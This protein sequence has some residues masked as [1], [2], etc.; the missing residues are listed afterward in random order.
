MA[1]EEKKVV[2]VGQ[3]PQEEEEALV[4]DPSNPVTPAEEAVLEAQN[5]AVEAEEKQLEA[6]GL[7]TQLGDALLGKEPQRI[8]ATEPPHSKA[9]ALG[10][11]HED[12]SNQS[13]FLGRT[14]PYPIYTVIFGALA[15]LTVTEILISGIDA[16][17]L[18]IPILLA[19]AVTKALLVI[20]Y[21][22]HLRTDSR[23]FTVT[24]IIPALVAL[25][26]MFYLLFVPPTY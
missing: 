13:V 12:H 21:Y 9:E 7:P 6:E 24:L 15:A 11:T 18:R 4:V 19:L 25:A 26:A 8:E 22:M 20:Y 2:Q 17:G 14:F 10:E 3:T 1:D 23:I 5:R 16:E